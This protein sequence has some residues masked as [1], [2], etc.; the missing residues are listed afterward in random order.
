MKKL[1][2]YPQRK[3]GKANKKFAEKGF[4]VAADA[5]AADAAPVDDGAAGGGR[6][7]KGGS[8]AGGEPRGMPL[9]IKG[10]RFCL[11]PSHFGRM[12]CF[13]AASGRFYRTDAEAGIG[14]CGAQM[15]ITI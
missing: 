8:F 10:P 2:P 9:Y 5:D 7:E 3:A 6:D 1:L 12:Q 13:M 4:Y 15:E 14:G 11:P